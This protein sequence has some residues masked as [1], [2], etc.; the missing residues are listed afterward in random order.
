MYSLALRHLE[1][2]VRREP[3][4]RRQFHL[5]IAYC[6]AGKQ[7]RGREILQAVLKTDGSA[8]EAAQA[9]DVLQAR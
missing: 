6:K 1:D 4:A 5:G 8:P 3:T 2:A 7:E 9:R